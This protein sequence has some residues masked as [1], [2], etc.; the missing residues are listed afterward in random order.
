MIEERKH[1]GSGGEV[2]AAN[3]NAEYWDRRYTPRAA[4]VPN[5]IRMSQGLE[6]K[7][8]TTGKYLNVIRE[9]NIILLFLAYSTR[10]LS[11]P[12]FRNLFVPP[13]LPSFLPSFISVVTTFTSR[14]R[15]S[16]TPPPPPLYTDA[17]TAMMRAILRR[18]GML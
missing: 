4:M 18:W 14:L 12:T 6:L 7:I 3:F 9:V 8:L 1:L 16:A 5:F 10:I 11:L 2:T 15:D 17:D 13:I